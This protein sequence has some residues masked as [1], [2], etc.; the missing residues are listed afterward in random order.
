MTDDLATKGVIDPYRMLTGRAEWRL[1]LRFDDADRRLTPLGREIGLG[2]VARTAAVLSLVALGVGE[3]AGDVVST[4]V[5]EAPSFGA[6]TVAGGALAIG[7]AGETAF[8]T[9][10]AGASLEECLS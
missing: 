2:C 4:A 8:G 1:L 6:A 10:V 3:L 5:L 7:I 9:F